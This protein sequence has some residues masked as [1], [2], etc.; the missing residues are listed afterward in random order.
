[1]PLRRT[2]IQLKDL[3][4]KI[5]IEKKTA[6]YMLGINS[7]TF[8]LSFLS[9]RRCSSIHRKVMG[10]GRPSSARAARV[11]HR[12]PVNLLDRWPWPTQPLIQ[13]HHSDADHCESSQ[14]PDDGK[15]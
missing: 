4:R 3:G 6:A 13:R 11:T 1:V 7:V 12:G 8:L 5:N 2:L 9:A 10:G 14:P 15:A